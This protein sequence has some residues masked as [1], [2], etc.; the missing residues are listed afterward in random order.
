MIKR[1]LVV[2]M[3]IIIL[4]GCINQ[5]ESITSTAIKSSTAEPLE[6]SSI[7]TGMSLHTELHYAKAFTVEYRDNYK[8]V[9]ILN[10]WRDANTTFTYIL[11]QR[12]TPIPKNI[13]DAQVIEIPVQ[14]MACLA[15]THLP[16]LEKLNALDELIAIGNPQYVNTPGV[17]NGLETGRIISVGN[18]PDV[19]IESLIE[20]NPD[21]ITTLA[22][23]SSNKDDYQLLM[24]KG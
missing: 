15:T 18:G 21:V 11:V 6:V 1:L 5:S 23:G 7:V 12:G 3:L 22:L 2:L 13:G 9:T 17:L 20:L 16:Y 10:P 14:R 24:Q 8:V 4:V 19:N